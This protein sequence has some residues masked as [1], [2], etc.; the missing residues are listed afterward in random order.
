[1]TLWTLN[2]THFCFVLNVHMFTDLTT[3]IDPPP[4]L[5]NAASAITIYEHLIVGLL[6]SAFTQSHPNFYSMILC[7]F[8]ATTSFAAIRSKLGSPAL[9]CNSP[10]VERRLFAIFN[11]KRSHVISG[12]SCVKHSKKN[13][14]EQSNS[15]CL[16]CVRFACRCLAGICRWNLIWPIRLYSS[17]AGCVPKRK[18][19]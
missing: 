9:Q 1:M 18:S 13:E 6:C 10:K 17:W 15:I 16:T 8:C 11:T 12:L 3:V 19:V 7:E 2:F 4:Q 14:K 5:P